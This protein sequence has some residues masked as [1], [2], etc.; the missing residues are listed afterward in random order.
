MKNS[1][2]NH[3]KQDKGTGA[4]EE[5]GNPDFFLPFYHQDNTGGDRNKQGNNQC[6]DHAD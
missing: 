3:G 2:Q 1:L 5:A 4:N 6:K